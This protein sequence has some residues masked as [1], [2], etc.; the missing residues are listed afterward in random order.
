MAHSISLSLSLDL[1]HIDT[2]NYLL[3][4]NAA[5]LYDQEGFILAA[6]PL[7]PHKGSINQILPKY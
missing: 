3:V 1:L 2:H 4:A 5:M 7:L 6:A